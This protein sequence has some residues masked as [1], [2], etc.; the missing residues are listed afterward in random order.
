VPGGT[1]CLSGA[2]RGEAGDPRAKAHDLRAPGI[3]L[4]ATPHSGSLET[5]S[6]TLT[7]FVT[8]QRVR[9]AINS[10][11][12]APTSTAV[13]RSEGGAPAAASPSQAALGL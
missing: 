4:V 2:S 1:V 7:Q 9:I 11:F 3:S 13:V 10:N 5:T 6:E 8:E 12:F